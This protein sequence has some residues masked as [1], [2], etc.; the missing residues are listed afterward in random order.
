MN[1]Q[2]E[3]KQEQQETVTQG[4]EVE[5]LTLSQEELQQMIGSE[6]DRRVTK[7]LQTAKEKWEQEVTEKIQKERSEAEEL[8]KLT[9]AERVQREF[10]MQQETFEQE[11]KQFQREKLE[12]QTVKSLQAE[13]LPTEFST[14]VLSDS[15]ETITQNIAL[16]KDKWQEAIEKAVVERLKGTTPK[17]SNTKQGITADDFR[18]MT[19]RDRVELQNQNP[20][21]YAQLSSR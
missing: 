7:A 20:E 4:T 9:E 16:F 14:F 11:R 18:R 3:V 15:A 12:L 6:A 10:Q 21:L 19:Y 13:N 2:A 17:G 1:E 5:N 8:A